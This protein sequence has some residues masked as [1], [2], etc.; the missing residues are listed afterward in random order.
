LLKTYFLRTEKQR[1]DSDKLQGQLRKKLNL[2]LEGSLN[3]F[4]T[5]MLRKCVSSINNWQK[6]G[7]IS[8][9]KRFF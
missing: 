5:V 3:A 2:L 4:A 8:K 1:V 7:E 9:S 6:E